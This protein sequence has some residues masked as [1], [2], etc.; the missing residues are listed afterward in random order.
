MK[1]AELLLKQIKLNSNCNQ[2]S[3]LQQTTTLQQAII[4]FSNM[5][6]YF[7]EGNFVSNSSI[8]QIRI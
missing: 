3:K 2:Q 4:Y 7:L 8:T 1:A 5:F 6:F